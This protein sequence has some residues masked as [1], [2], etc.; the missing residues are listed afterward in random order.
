MDATGVGGDQRCQKGRL[1]MVRDVIKMKICNK[2]ADISQYRGLFD[3]SQGVQK[4]KKISRWPDNLARSGNTVGA[5]YTRGYTLGDLKK[6]G[7]GEEGEG[8]EE[9]EEEEEESKSHKT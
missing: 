2:M 8:E 6:M 1:R 4:K 5:E 3:F 9:E 7:L